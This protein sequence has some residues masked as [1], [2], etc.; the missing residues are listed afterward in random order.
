MGVVLGPSGLVVVE[1]DDPDAEPVGFVN[2]VA[3]DFQGKPKL[4]AFASSSKRVVDGDGR[5]ARL[6]RNVPDE[7]GVWPSRVANDALGRADS[8]SSG[9]GEAA[10]A[11]LCVSGLPDSSKTPLQIGYA[12]LTNPTR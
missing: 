3:T 9:G 5:G 6:K 4:V 1:Y 7:G 12:E 11:T 8:S 10:R 2:S